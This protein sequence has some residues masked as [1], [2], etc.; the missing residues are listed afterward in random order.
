MEGGG[1][2]GHQNVARNDKIARFGK[3]IINIS[4]GNG[5]TKLKRNSGEAHRRVL[6]YS[7]VIILIL[8]GGG[9]KKGGKAPK[10]VGT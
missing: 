8:D 7:Q 9:G 10:R 4:A 2:E 1:W 5:H 6:S 3:N